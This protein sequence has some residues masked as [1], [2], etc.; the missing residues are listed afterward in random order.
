M[1]VNQMILVEFINKE[2]WRFDGDYN[3]LFNFVFTEVYRYYG[4]LKMICNKHRV[5]L[6]EYAVI[7]NALYGPIPADARS[8][9][10]TEQQIDLYNNMRQTTDEMQLEVESFYM[11][12][13]I[14]LDKMAFAIEY[15]FGRG[16]GKE[17]RHHSM[18]QKL[19]NGDLLKIEHYCQIKGIIIPKKLLGKMIDIQEVISSFRD[20][21]ITHLRSSRIVRGV[22]LDGRMSLGKYRPRDEKDSVWI[23]SESLDGILE[24]VDDYVSQIVA[25]IQANSEKTA[26]PV[27]L[28]LM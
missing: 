7:S 24:S 17:L 14:F 9:T 23:S 1:N 3:N 26:L 13:K 28:K 20:D 21:N 27:K 8:H 10:M 4:F 16:Q 19:H 22:G 5:T 25:F 18:V 12:A 11:F 6:L 2:R 15:Y